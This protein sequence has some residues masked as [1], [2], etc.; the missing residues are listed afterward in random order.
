MQITILQR[1]KD[2][3]SERERV[4]KSN[5]KEKKNTTNRRKQNRIKSEHFSL[6][7][8]KWNNNKYQSLPMFVEYQRLN[9]QSQIFT[10]F[11]FTEFDYFFRN[12]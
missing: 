7:F 2:N 10:K 8:W 12:L 4:A 5:Q 6:N 9:V 3:S 11:D 1:T